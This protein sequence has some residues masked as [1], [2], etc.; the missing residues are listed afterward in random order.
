M[1]RKPG[2][3]TRQQAAILGVL[4]DGATHSRQELLDACL[5]DMMSVRTLNVAITR[6]RKLLRPKGQDIVCVLN[7]KR[8]NYRWVRLL[9]HTE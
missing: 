6:V 8:I 4:K 3:Y 7:N 1:A 9:N 5:D 2:E